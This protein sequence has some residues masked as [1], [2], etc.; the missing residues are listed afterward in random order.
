MSGQ[1]LLTVILVL[2][3]LAWL[4]QLVWLF[5]YAE[6]QHADPFRVVSG[7]AIFFIA[8]APVAMRSPGLVERLADFWDRLFGG[9]PQAVAVPRVPAR[10]LING[11]QLPLD[12]PRTRIGRYPNNEI[13]L[14]HSTVSAYHAEII[15]RPDG[16]HE[17]QDNGSR[18]GTRV[19]GDIVTNRI[20][21]E[22]DLITLGAA[23]MHYLGP[24]S[25]E[26]QAAMA[27]DYRRRDPQHDD[28]DPY[29]HR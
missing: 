5:R 28:A 25:R 2:A 26:S 8:A 23:S 1:T 21:K 22:G 15:E 10:L 20:L 4:A 6:Q 9:R 29:D 19:N 13:V 18:N 12:Q 17:I 7:A 24:S 3:V 11:E 14:D 27:A 16:R